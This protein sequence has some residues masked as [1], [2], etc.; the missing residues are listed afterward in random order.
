MVDDSS[1]SLD[2][3]K[4]ISKIHRS[5]FDE[6]R[7]TEWKLVFAI[8]AFYFGII[9]TNISNNFLTDNTNPVINHSLQTTIF[10]VFFIITLLSILYLLFIHKANFINKS[11]AEDAEENIEIIING[12][13]EINFKMPEKEK[14]FFEKILNLKYGCNWSWFFQSAILFSLCII[15]FH[16]LKL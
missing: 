1:L 2:G 5:Q 11:I 7:K 10:Y 8:I 3:L 13:K 15:T 9:T 16:I 12:G 14:S 4:H 6:R